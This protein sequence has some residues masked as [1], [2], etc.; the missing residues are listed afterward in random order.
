MFFNKI[1]NA[2][3]GLL[4]PNTYMIPPLLT[5]LNIKP[6]FHTN[7]SVGP[8]KYTPKHIH[9][10]KIYTHTHKDTLI[11]F[12]SWLSYAEIDVYAVLVCHVNT[13]P[14]L[15]VLHFIFN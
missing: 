5:H 13:V 12:K 15:P 11:Y 9:K 3:T 10:R 8:F 4:Y 2:K 1:I 7:T 6:D 14:P